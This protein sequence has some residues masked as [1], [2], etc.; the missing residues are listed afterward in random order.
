MNLVEQQSKNLKVI[1]IKNAVKN[2][3][4]IFSIPYFDQ[5]IN[6]FSEKKILL[7]PYIYVIKRK[8]VLL[9][10]FYGV[11]LVYLRQINRKN[12]K[13]RNVIYEKKTIICD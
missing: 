8:L 1:G 2:V 6:D 7:K 13:G 10:I 11:C 5:F 9:T 12:K 4:F 3:K